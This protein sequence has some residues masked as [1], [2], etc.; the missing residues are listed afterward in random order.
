V[1]L[2]PGLLQQKREELWRR[3]DLNQSPP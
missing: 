1:N 2:T 3:S